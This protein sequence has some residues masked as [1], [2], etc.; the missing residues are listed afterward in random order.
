[1]RKKDWNKKVRDKYADGDIDTCYES[2][3]LAIVEMSVRDYRK[4]LEAEMKCEDLNARRAIRELETF[5]KSD[6][7][8]Q[9]SRLDG[10]LLIKNVRKIILN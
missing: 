2:L 5:F 1:M 6:W 10:R 7:F 8:E 9:L 4:A 3:C